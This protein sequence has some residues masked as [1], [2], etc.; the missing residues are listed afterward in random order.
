SS[1]H[2]NTHSLNHRSALS[3][4]N[5]VAQSLQGICVIIKI[6]CVSPTSV[7]DMDQTT[8]CVCVRVCVC[9]CVCVCECECDCTCVCECECECVCVCVCVCVSVCVC[10]CMQNVYINIQPVYIN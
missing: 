9:V 1:T 10:V 8:E 7:D 3:L 2:S 6:C 5:E 4:F